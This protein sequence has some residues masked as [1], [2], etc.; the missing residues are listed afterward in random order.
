MDVRMEEA[1]R[2]VGGRMPEPVNGELLVPIRRISTDSRTIEKD[3]LFFALKGARFDG[4]DFIQEAFGKGVRH[5]VISELQ[6]VPPDM[7]RSARFVKVPD[8][9]KAYGDLAKF[10]RQKFKIP[11]IAIT[12]SSGK[13]T[14]K[15]LV[16]H[17]LSQQFRVLRN[18]G[19]EN[20]LIGV[21][22]TIFQLGRE[23]EAL[24]LEM[25]TNTH[26]EIGRLS[27]IIDPQIGIIT[28]IGPAHLEGL[29]TQAGVFKEKLELVANMRRGG[30]VI[31]NGEDPWLKDVTCGVQ[32]RI[33]VGLSKGS[34]ELVADRIWCHETGNSFYVNGRVY[35][36]Q[37]LGRHNILNCLFAIAA[38]ETLGVEGSA[39]QKTVADFKPVAG[40][41]TLKLIDGIHFLDDSYNSNP[42]SFKA[43]LET[44][45]EF[46]TRER[47]GVVCGDML[48]LGDRSEMFHREMGALVAEMLFDFLI[49][50]GP[51][52][53]SLAQEARHRGLDAKKVHWVKDSREAGRCC[54]EIALAGDKILVK[55]SRGMQMEKVFECFTTS[56]TH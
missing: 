33:R 22:K 27:S 3:D 52:S 39:I 54:R 11:S 25:G 2:A 17:V 26:G 6:D 12:G 29:K 9:L 24:V 21:P 55:G 16:A 10:Y 44:L 51:M 49:A 50:A 15:E 20:N 35:E 1:I 19:T 42:S 46:K 18:R 38:A 53:K 30:I 47:R 7:K 48:E 23:H 28:Q 41:M 36:T 5:F 4:H 14:V 43:A 13:T 31:L 37:L 45:K 32:R 56:S 8:T 34:G 40:R